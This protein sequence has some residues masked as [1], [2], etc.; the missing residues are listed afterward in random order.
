[1]KLIAEGIETEEK[2]TTL[3]N[4]G[5]YAGQGYFLNRLAETFLDAPG[6]VKDTILKCK[7]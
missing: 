3:I 4:L 6:N 5:V 7:N 2:L 1:M